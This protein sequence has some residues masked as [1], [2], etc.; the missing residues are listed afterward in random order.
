MS[1]CEQVADKNGAI[2]LKGKYVIISV[3]T[4]NIIKQTD[5]RVIVSIDADYLLKMLPIAITNERK[6]V[7]SK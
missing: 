4:K 7:A 5:N 2:D 3:P 6:W 1:D